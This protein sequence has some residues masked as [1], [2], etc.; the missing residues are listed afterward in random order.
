MAMQVSSSRPASILGSEDYS[1]Y[2]SMSE[3]ELIQM[4]IEQSL[5]ENNSGPTTAHTHQ[6]L[7]ASVNAEATA[8]CRNNRPTAKQAPIAA[9]TRNREENIV[10]KAIISG[11][12]DSLN[13]MMKSG[14]KLC[15]PNKEGWLPL[16]EAAYYGSL[17]CVKL[18]LKAYPSTIDQRTLQE[19]TAL[20]FSAVKGHIECITY[21]LQ[22]GAEPDIANKSRETPLYKACERMNAEAAQLLVEYRADVNHR[23]NRGW[24]A[25][26]EAVARNAIDIIDIL[27]KGGAKIESKNCYGITP[28]FVAAQSG[29]MEA[30][31]YIAKCGADINTQANDNASALFEASKNGHDDIVEFLLAQGADANKPNKDG[32]LPIHIAAKRR[33]NDDIVSMLIPVTSRIRVKRSGISPLHIAAE[34]NND[35]ILE[36]LI[37]VGYDVNCTLSFDRARLYEDRRS[38][39]LYFAVMNNNINATQMLLEAGANPN[40]DIINPLLISIRHGCFKT[41]QMLLSH[42]ANI[43]AYISTHPTSFPATIMF[44]MKYLSLLKFIMDLGCDADSCFTCQYGSGPHPPTE[45]ATRRYDTTHVP[46]RK[47]AKIVQFCEMVSTPE[48][49]R[50]AGPIIDVLLDYVGNVKLCSRLQEHLDSYEDWAC[51]KEKSQLPRSL[52]HL[53]RLKVRSL[54]GR[55]RIK[56]VDT[57]PLPCRMIR[58]LTYDTSSEC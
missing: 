21:L 20:Y 38:T 39:A 19:E 13:E 3:E 52:S 29:Q 47:Q 27:V 28:L 57:L 42:G 51:I 26:H 31:R 23:C 24:T 32:W 15:E 8:A 4:A 41:M 16:H 56:L 12:V 50:W 35:D 54:I 9:N 11:D 7:S 5:T 44:S 36:E 22:S 33:D 17:E 34:R 1:L 30:L 40:I 45:E 58:Y 14:K 43:N 53:C 6:K 46:E 37:N 25:L 49:S 18:L 55:N 48:M 2:S 10:E